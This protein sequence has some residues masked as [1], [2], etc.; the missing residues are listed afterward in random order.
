MVGVAHAAVHK[1]PPSH[2]L[3]VVLVVALAAA[4][5]AGRKLGLW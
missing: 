4:A 5:V 2:L 1:L 3:I